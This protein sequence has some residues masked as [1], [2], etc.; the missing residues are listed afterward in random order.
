MQIHREPPPFVP[1]TITLESEREAA[2]M[3]K[4]LE[5]AEMHTAALS[6]PLRGC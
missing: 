4:I 3:E 6:G 5:R 2:V 1:V